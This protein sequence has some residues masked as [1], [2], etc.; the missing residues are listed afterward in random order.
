MQVLLVTMV[1]WT[2][3]G[4]GM[5]RSDRL[6]VQLAGLERGEAPLHRYLEEYCNCISEMG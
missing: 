2:E 6:G 3:V 4:D 5:G 1:E